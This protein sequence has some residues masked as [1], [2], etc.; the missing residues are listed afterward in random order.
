MGTMSEVNKRMTFHVL[1][2]SA[3][4]YALIALAAA[5]GK[6]DKQIFT[7]RD[8]IS[9]PEGYHVEVTYQLVPDSKPVVN[10][11]ILENMAVPA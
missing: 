11:D 8:I 6:S 4:T 2:N 10:L 1:R 5:L 3:L 7:Q 9:I